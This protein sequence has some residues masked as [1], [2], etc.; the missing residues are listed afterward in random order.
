[1]EARS[2]CLAREQSDFLLLGSRAARVKQESSE[3]WG[4]QQSDSW[5]GPQSL[6]N[7]ALSRAK[8]STL[9]PWRAAAIWALLAHL[10]S[11][12]LSPWPGARAPLCTKLSL[13]VNS[14]HVDSVLPQWAITKGFPLPL[15]L[16]E[17]PH[18][19]PSPS[20]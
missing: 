2:A 5:K 1:M 16:G 14:A 7:L 18:S 6:F 8:L 19:C 3:D 4:R 15:P 11:G 9:R 17:I 10:G 13:L 12:E 20:F